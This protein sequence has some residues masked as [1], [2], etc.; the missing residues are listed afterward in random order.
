M[1]FSATQRL[2]S[3]ILS[4]LL[5]P[6]LSPGSGAT[7]YHV[8][9]TGSDQASGTS[10]APFETI[11]RA[12]ASLKTGDTCVIH[13]GVYRETVRP[14]SSGTPDRP[15]S[16]VAAAGEDVVVSGAEL[17]AGDW[18]RADGA[19]H[20]VSLPTYPGQVFVDGEPM[21]EARWPNAPLA[22]VMDRLTVRAE[23][24]QGTDYEILCDPTLPRGDFSDAR[25]LI[26]P[27]SMWNNAVRKVL[28]YESGKSFRF[29]PPFK[30]IQEK[31]H[32]DDPYRPKPTNP[33]ILFGSRAALDQPGEWFH[34][35]P[36]GTL[37]LLFPA[38]ASPQDSVVEVRS[39]DYG[40][41][42]SGLA[43]IQ[44]E[45]IR[46]FATAIDMRDARNCVVQD[47]MLRWADHFSTPDGYRIPEAKNIVS[48]VDNTW[49]HCR[50]TG[51]AGAAIRLIGKGNRVVNCIIEEANYLGVN[52]AAVDA[53]G[54]ENALIEHCSIFRAGRDLVGHGRAKGI[55]ILYN[56][57]HHPNLLS[58]DTGATYAWK[59]DAFGSEIAYNWIHHITG[60]TNGVYLDNFCNGFHVHHN[61]IWNARNIRLNSD[62]TNHLIANNTL[63]GDQPFG[64]FCYYNHTPN[65]EGTR[66]VN[67]LIVRRVDT[68]DP[69]IFVQGERG[70]VYEHNGRGAVD[71]RGV[72]EKGSTVIDAG[73]AIPRIT[74]GFLGK[75][76][77]LG[78]YE[79][80]APYWK[81][82][83]DWGNVATVV[84]LAW[85][86]PPPLTEASMIRE[87]LCVWLDAANAASLETNSNQ[88]VTAWH[89]LSDAKQRLV[90][91]PG[92]SLVSDGLNGRPALRFEGRAAISLGTF[93]SDLGG[94]SVFLVA[95]SE[96]S[97]K[98]LWQRLLATWDG[99]TSDDYL[100]P[101]WNVS[102]PEQGTELP[103][104][105]KLFSKQL[106]HAVLSNVVLG[107]SARGKAH[108]FIGNIAELLVFGRRLDPAD[109]ERVEA[110]L[111]S[112]WGLE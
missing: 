98:H 15:V 84:D 74:D 23:A 57:L 99:K 21:M 46:L 70:P 48:G 20:C 53:G 78:A 97:G 6:M 51:A 16:V 76:P 106:D 102:R 73:V 93:R 87:G 111:S 45:G 103:F 69:S 49:R 17:V 19:A 30:A 95:A 83:A 9:V 92:C 11:S 91:A 63:Y 8:A 94:V 12:A 60:H 27:G 56:D 24:G 96:S 62:A 104:P 88:Q 40:F 110:Y 13:A 10:A 82:G 71:S 61:V 77:D 107:G 55:K 64:T 42:L 33:Y 100:D 28:G 52:C 54:S 41:D 50:I 66:I 29:D 81:A 26:W 105:P 25:V 37:T 5:L 68:K 35:G 58:N 101:S 79:R 7:E 2:H 47:C 34:D 80:G 90:L 3:A 112:K 108:F 39:R 44:I 36:A 32:K 65:Q 89:D 1:A 38:A 67:N 59:T 75:A 72:P 18:T 85:Q 14:A 31:Y 86:V 22:P 109:A 4:A 43:H